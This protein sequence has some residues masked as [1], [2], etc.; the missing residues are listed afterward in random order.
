MRASR[1][2]AALVVASVLGAAACAPP[3]AAMTTDIGT[4]TAHDGFVRTE[5]APPALIAMP[6]GVDVDA[7]WRVLPG[8]F[9]SIEIPVGVI[10]AR[11]RIIGQN[12]ITVSS[13]DGRAIRTYFR[14]AYGGAG[15]SAAASYRI[16]FDLAAQPRRSGTRTELMVQ[17]AATASSTDPSRSGNVGCTST[18]ELEKLL[19]SRLKTAL[20]A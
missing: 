12:R 17:T 15:P 14:C 4:A 19:E 7:V 13:I 10:D 9:A 11:N 2:S 20:G 6:L 8:V 3:P 5:A 1:S 18:G 16:M